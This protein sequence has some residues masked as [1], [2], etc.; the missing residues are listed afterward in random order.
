[1][2]AF[3]IK[4]W[5]TCIWSAS[6]EAKICCRKTNS[7]C[8]HWKTRK[9]TLIPSTWSKME[10]CWKN[11]KNLFS[12]HLLPPIISNTKWP[13]TTIS[14]TYLSLPFPLL[15][16]FISKNYNSNNNNIIIRREILPLIVNTVTIKRI[17]SL[18]TIKTSNI[19]SLLNHRGTCKWIRERLRLNSDPATAIR[20]CLLPWI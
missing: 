3:R 14:L 16:S 1:M 2:E 12:I 13:P 5:M 19:K 4:N 15:H 6:R 10:T 18:I 17:A 7:F 11:R 20:T 8:T 9:Q